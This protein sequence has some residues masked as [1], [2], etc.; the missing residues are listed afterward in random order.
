MADFFKITA[1]GNDPASVE[2]ELFGD[3][4]EHG[5]NVRF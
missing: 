5:K 1:Q 2:L 3:V 4:C